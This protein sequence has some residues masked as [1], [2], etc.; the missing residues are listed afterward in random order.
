MSN[1][2]FQAYTDYV[3]TVNNQVY[4]N[5]MTL[6]KTTNEFVSEVIKQNPYKD[7]FGVM[8]AFVKT[9]NKNKK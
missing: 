1:S 4:N 6:T 2:M 7:V 5:W 3:T 8:D 9:D